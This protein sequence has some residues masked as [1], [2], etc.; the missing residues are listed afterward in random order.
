MFFMDTVDKAF[1]SPLQLYLIPT[2]TA[3]AESTGQ[4]CVKSISHGFTKHS[5]SFKLLMTIDENFH[6]K[7][8]P[9]IQ[10]KWYTKLKIQFLLL[11]ANLVLT[12][13]FFLSIFNSGVLL[14]LEK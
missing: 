7:L 4:T 2:P 3:K 1:F 14:S 13:T 12:K 8:F 6:Q 11:S 9:M 5:L 10:V